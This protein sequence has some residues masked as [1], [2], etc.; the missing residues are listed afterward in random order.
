MIWG[1]VL[2]FAALLLLFVMWTMSDPANEPQLKSSLPEVRY[3]VK[4]K[5]I[6]IIYE[7]DLIPTIELAND[8]N[9]EAKKRAIRT[10]HE[11][12]NRYRAG[13]T[14]FIEDLEGY[15]SKFTIISKISQDKWN[16]WRNDEESHESAQYINEKFEEHIMASWELNNLIK[17]S[18]VEF[19]DDL[20]ANRNQML[21]EMKI[22]LTSDNV[23]VEVKMSESEWTSFLANYE[24]QFNLKLESYG[25]D[26]VTYP[27]LSLFAGECLY[28]GLKNMAQTTTRMVAPI[29]ATFGTWLASSISAAYLSMSTAVGGSTVIYSLEGG[30]AGSSAG[31]VGTVVGIVAGCA[32]GLVVDLYYEKRF[33]E[34]MTVELTNVLNQLETLIINGHLSKR[35]LDDIY[36]EINNK[37][38]YLSQEASLRALYEREVN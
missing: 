19:V 34:K 20:T 23:P 37:I 24:K 32:V 12:F 9:E 28:F 27:I 16:E 3:E 13:I 4:L 6:K 30:T 11:G 26:A 31:P 33:E 38:K 8:R 5:D 15:G 22:N 36:T 7:K 29:M 21:A 35:G 18:I 14:E 2:M 25:G 10:I 17:Y 1:V